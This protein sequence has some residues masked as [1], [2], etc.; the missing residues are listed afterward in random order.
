MGDI[1]KTIKGRMWPWSKIDLLEA[2]LK[3]ALEG[4]DAASARN[5]ELRNSLAA[6]QEQVAKRESL[7]EQQW[8]MQ[9][10]VFSGVDFGFID[11]LVGIN[12]R[13]FNSELQCAKE[14]YRRGMGWREFPA[15]L[16][17]YQ[18]RS[19]SW[20]KVAGWQK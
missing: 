18:G 16:A 3:A 6:A 9:A 1:W 5:G 19:G 15:F 13:A 2:R 8:L 17:E 4:W 14:C 10:S 12:Q 11:S 20:W 7:H